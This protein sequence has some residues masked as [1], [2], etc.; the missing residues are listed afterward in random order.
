MFVRPALS[1]SGA[2]ELPSSRQEPQ[3]T[4]IT[5]I[6][7]RGLSKTVELNL[8]PNRR[9]LR[10]LLTSELHT[11]S[12]FSIKL[13]CVKE[14][15]VLQD[16]FV[17]E[18][19]HLHVE[20]AVLGDVEQAFFAPPFDRVYAVTGFA[21]PERRLRDIVQPRLDPCDFVDF[22]QDIECAEL[23]REIKDGIAHQDLIIEV[24]D[25]ES[26]NKICSE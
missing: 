10:F 2:V 12:L 5:Q 15:P 11:D 8:F 17:H 21:D 6:F 19:G 4:P 3:I 23:V 9:N 24:E 25:I 14:F 13:I 16:V 1:L 26:D 20:A 22:D 7:F 18:S